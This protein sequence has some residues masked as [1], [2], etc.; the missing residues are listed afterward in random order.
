MWD[1][2]GGQRD[3]YYRFYLLDEELFLRPS[4]AHIYNPLLLL[5][6]GRYSWTGDG[7]RVC[8]QLQGL[9]LELETDASTVEV[10]GRR[11]DN[12]SGDTV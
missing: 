1:R 4:Q 10:L 5:D 8:V 6:K 7:I 12:E 11:R 3:H 9:E 2:K